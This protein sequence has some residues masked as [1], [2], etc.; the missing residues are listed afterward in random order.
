[1]ISPDLCLA[2]FIRQL[3]PAITPIVTWQLE[4][5][6]SKQFDFS[7]K[8]AYPSPDRSNSKIMMNLAAGLHDDVPYFDR[9]FLGLMHMLK[10]L[11]ATV[12]TG[13]PWIKSEINNN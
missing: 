3:I 8:S 11:G 13:N 7:N 10:K 1:M 12:V 6:R 9:A 5:F 4:P 2:D